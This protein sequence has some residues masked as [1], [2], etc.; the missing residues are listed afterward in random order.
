MPE[1][2][3]TGI[4]AKQPTTGILLYGLPGTGKTQFVRAFASLANATMLSLTAADFRHS[5]VGESEKRIQQIFGYARDHQGSFVIFI[6]EADSIFRS[7]SLEGNSTSHVSDLNQFL[8]E[9]DGIKSSSLRNVMVIAASNRPFD[10][11]EGILRRLSRRILVDLPNKEGREAILKIHLKNETVANDVN[12]GEL[13]RITGDYTGSD[14]K[15]L[16][17]EAALICL[18][19]MRLG[20][21]QGMYPVSGGPNS[22]GVNQQARA[23]RWEHLRAAKKNTRPA[24]KSDIVEKIRDFH[25]KFGNTS[26]K[27]AIDPV[28]QNI[29][30]KNLYMG[31]PV[32]NAM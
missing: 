22:L 10:I 28:K 12:L 6:D 25:D 24:P 21:M 20:A 16:V 5:H 14:L 9:M 31:D 19:Q 32:Q 30:C 29:T 8:A 23:L 15:D 17:H 1:Q 13:A 3:K 2:F 11:D 26:Q 4:L 18:R 27:R 7:R